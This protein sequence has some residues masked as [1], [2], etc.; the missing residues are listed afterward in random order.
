MIPHDDLV[1]RVPPL[2]GAGV[3]AVGTGLGGLVAMLAAVDADGAAK[4]SL[5]VVGIAIAV[6]NAISAHLHKR[7]N[8]RREAVIDDA[9]TQGR[10][11]TLTLMEAQ[12]KADIEAGKP[13]RWVIL[14]PDYDEP[15]GR[16]GEHRT[17]GSEGA[18]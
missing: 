2:L 9:L 5:M 18:K 17:R 8:D 3:S 1:G 14:L 4:W 16:T 7:E 13:P 11:R 15:S 6:V 12:N 10:L